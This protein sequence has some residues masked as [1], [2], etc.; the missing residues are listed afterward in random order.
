MM[1]W[2]YAM[3]PGS[4]ILPDFLRTC[5]DYFSFKDDRIR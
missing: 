4:F 5:A 2:M 3:S 1:A